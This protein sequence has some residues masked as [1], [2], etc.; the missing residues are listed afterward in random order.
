MD[1]GFG[2]GFRRDKSWWKSST[3]LMDGN[4]PSVNVD[5]GRDRYA[6]ANV[7]PN[8]VVNG[9]F[10]SGAAGWTT[11]AGVTISDGAAVFSGVAAGA[12]M[13]CTLSG[14]ASGDI[15]SITY[16]VASWTSGQVR[17]SLET[18]RGASRS[19]IGGF[20]ELIIATQANPRLFIQGVAGS[21]SFS[22]T[23][24]IVRKLS[25]SLGPELVQN[26]TF[27]T[28]LDGWTDGSTA[29]SAFAWSSANGGQ[30]IT[31]TDAVNAARLSQSVSTIAG[32][33][34]VLSSTGNVTVR[35]GTT[36]GGTELLGLAAGTARVFVA[37]GSTS[38][39][40]VT[41]VVNGATLDNVSVRE[42]LVGLGPELVTNG[43]FDNDLSG[44][45]PLS[46]TD[47]TSTWVNGAMQ[48]VRGAGGSSGAPASTTIA[49][50]PG[51]TYVVVA[52][53]VGAATCR[54]ALTGGQVFGDGSGNMDV[55]AGAT[56]TKT[57]TATVS[58]SAVLLYPAGPSATV[59][60]NYVS[61]REVLT[62]QPVQPV[63]FHELFAMSSG[64]K[65]VV[66]NDNTLKTVPANSPAFD[67]TGGRRLLLESA[68]TNLCIYA[69]AIESWTLTGPAS[70][71]NGGLCPDGVNNWRV[72]TD[73]TT[74]SV[75]SANQ[76]RSVAANT[77]SYVYSILMLKDPA[78]TSNAQM[79][80]QFNG[81]TTQNCRATFDPRTCTPMAVLNC[82]SGSIDLG[83]YCLIWMAA[84]NNGTNTSLQQLLL[85]ATS[86]AGAA[87]TS[88]STTA[89][90]SVSV[91][92]AQLEVGT[93]PSSRILTAA[94]SVTR[95]T[96]VCAFSSL[97][98]LCITTP[99]ASMVWRGS[100]STSVA[101][102]GFI[103]QAGGNTL[104]K[105]AFGT[106]SAVV[107]DGDVQNVDPSV[108]GVLPGTIGAA[109]G[110]ST[111][112][113]ALSVN[114]TAAASDAFTMDRQMPP[115]YFGTSNGM[116]AGA[117]HAI[118]AFVVWPLKG[119]NT[120]LQAQAR[121]YA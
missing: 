109:F 103:G 75:A 81:G 89:T 1:L 112:A 14:I 114:G 118:G 52:G 35:A 99:A 32:R 97:L 106:L 56:S 7:G 45:S 115:L 46:G 110:W 73:A 48:I 6:L 67:Y 78:A 11:D 54:V 64:A 41:T 66:A 79:V 72:V 17:A 93:A 63:R 70:V 43:G 80:L 102:Q 65:T 5:F 51:R 95:V 55:A 101:G 94:S 22:V 116:T 83:A 4:M 59:I 90:G 50:I 61:V 98:N 96:D 9:D 10:S 120:N 12:G 39:I 108:A 100:V 23:G 53:N 30:A 2:F 88:Q 69:V 34:Y 105:A 19:A 49:L 8:L 38:Y 20:N 84:A 68:A 28:S 92:Y 25:A 15:F 121:V 104:L 76:S 77:S 29:P 18:S 24:I 37:A 44:W 86:A 82:V 58:N 16:T 117:I 62:N 71:T 111:G 40:S 74:S 57:F 3:F 27:N 33:T 31:S 47:I 13:Y 87:G 26:G 107:L 113:R 21:D 119:T 85:P 42:V 91:V 36:N 60:M